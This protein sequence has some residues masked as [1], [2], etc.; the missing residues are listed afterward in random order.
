MDGKTGRKYYYNRVTKTTSW[1][2]PKCMLAGGSGGGGI[3]D[4]ATS[5]VV[6]RTTPSTYN[7]IQGT[8]S[9]GSSKPTSATHSRQASGGTITG[10]QQLPRAPAP[11]V[12]SEWVEA[13]DPTS[14]RSYWYNKDTKETTWSA[15]ITSATVTPTLTASSNYNTISSTTAAPSIHNTASPSAVSYSYTSTSAGPSRQGT[16]KAIT[17]TTTTDLSRAMAA[18]AVADE[19]D[20]E[21][22]HRPQPK[23]PESVRE[24]KDLHSI[25]DMDGADDDDDDDHSQ[26]DDHNDN[27]NNNSAA[28]IESTTQ[29]VRD[30]LE[31]GDANGGT[32]HLNFSKHRKGWFKRTFRVGK[33]FTH[34][35][36]M[37]Y[38]KSLIKKSLLKENRHLDTVAVQLFKNIMSYMG[39]RKSSKNCKEH[40][41][42]IIRQCL[43]APTGIRDECYVQLM[44]QTTRNPNKPSEKRGWE[45]L[46]QCLCFFPPSKMI[47]DSVHEYI[48]KAIVREGGQ[49]AYV[50]SEANQRT[51]LA[52]KREAHGVLTLAY[53]ALIYLPQVQAVGARLNVPCE[54]EL[55]ALV[56]FTPIH[57]NVY[58]CN[59]CSVEPFRITPFTTVRS[60]LVE[61]CTRLQISSA[62]PLFALYESQGKHPV[63]FLSDSEAKAR[64]GRS[65][66]VRLADTA[67]AMCDTTFYSQ[68]KLNEEQVCDAEARV[69]DVVSNW[70]NTPLVEEMS[71]G[72]LGDE[73]LQQ[74]LCAA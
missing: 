44:K 8:A 43:A 68:R 7:T 71:D 35:K 45:L 50:L 53:L 3:M 38:K 20:D 32:E 36:L 18:I 48:E 73:G 47:V 10:T 19:K 60:L 69:L 72:E 74:R 11:S 34:D 33:E 65:A 59:D 61:L 46:T 40:C 52:T 67:E 14:G 12:A 30:R 57:M 55:A 13:K 16:M 27:N 51:V 66:D 17:A 64:E 23:A 42:K 62:A 70:E 21:Q 28:S 25:L 37:S 5:T 29:N 39:D 9:A 24:K 41:K 22:S 56:D 26:H 15:P 31:A 63:L 1:S 58:T 4:T 54:Y 6:S 49:V 2:K